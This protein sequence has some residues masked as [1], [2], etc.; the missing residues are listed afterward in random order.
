M[1]LSYSD[2][3]RSWKQGIIK[4]KPDIEANQITKSSID[5]RMGNLATILIENKGLT[6]WP[7][8]SS[9]EGIYRDE[10]IK[11]RLIIKPNHLV[12]V[13]TH[14]EVFMPP[15]LCAQVEGKSSLARFGLAVHITS[16]HI[17]PSFEGHIA[18]EL[19][20]HNPNNLELHPGDRVCQLIVS[21]VT[22]PIPKW[23]RGTG[24]YQGQVDS[25]PKPEMQ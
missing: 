10:E 15:N 25:K 9:S 19:Y 8:G 3:L 22:R 24:R 2:L 4:F 20:N 16:P 17:H 11:D 7:I 5:L 23:L 21:Q 18:L 13:A 1:I 14:E 6:I 12:L